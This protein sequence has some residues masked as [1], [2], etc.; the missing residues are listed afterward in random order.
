MNT[1]TASSASASASASVPASSSNASQDKVMVIGAGFTIEGHVQGQGTL[2]VSGTVKG[3]IQAD[4]VKLS[5]TAHV[6][7]RIECQQLDMAGRLDG[8]FQS[9]DVVVRAGAVVIGEEASVSTGTCLVAGAIS[10]PLQTNQLKVEASGQLNGHISAKQMDVHGHVQGEVNAEDLVVRSLGTIEGRVVYGNLSM[11]RGSNVNGQLQR[12]DRQSAP[13]AAK[14]NETVVIH[15]PVNIVQQL[16][17]NP[18]SLQLSLANGDAT[19]S[20][21]SVDREHAWLVLGKTEFNQLI[22]RGETLT[23]RLQAGTEELVFTLPPDA[24]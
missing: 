4:I 12:N 20:W 1:T 19:P 8:R 17:K 22:A 15:L 16:R 14:V 7:G 11:E 2:L 3:S 10:G 18:N 24:Q 13:T 5:E 21:I 9:A 6:A 23:L